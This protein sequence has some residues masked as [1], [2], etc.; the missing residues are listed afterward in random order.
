[1]IG[2]GRP[3][4][5][6]SRE[7]GRRSRLLAGGVLVGLL[8]FAGAGG[9]A[10]AEPAPSALSPAGRWYTPQQARAG[11]EVYRKYCVECHGQGGRGTAEDWRKMNT[12]GRFP[13]P[14]LNGTGHAWHHPRQTLL[15]TLTEGGEPL[16][17][18]MPAFGDRLNEEE[19]LAAIAY[20]QSLWPDDIYRNWLETDQA[21]T[22]EEGG[23][24]KLFFG[25]P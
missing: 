25:K 11:A 1:M 2:V 6:A 8:F 7:H 10:A 23:S 12:D 20:L 16:G 22:D 19:M 5:P 13:P 21:S 18:W 14:P 15:Q 9:A 3:A 4:F 17:G 24:V